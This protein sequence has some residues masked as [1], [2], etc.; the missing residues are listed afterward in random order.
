MNTRERATGT[1][2]KRKVFIEPMFAFDKT[3]ASEHS[4]SHTKLKKKNES[5]TNV[6]NSE[7]KD[8]LYP[9]TAGVSSG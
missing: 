8:K 5:N 1:S 4:L 9:R 6:K 2:N 3:Q 7:Y